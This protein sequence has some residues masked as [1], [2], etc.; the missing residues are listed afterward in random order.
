[1][2][3][4]GAVFTNDRYPRATT[5]DLSE[6]RT[7]E[8]DDTTRPTLVREGASIGAR[9]VVGDDL[10]I[11]RFALVGMGAVVTKSVRGLHAGRRHPGPGGRQ[12]LP[13]R[14]RDGAVRETAA[15]RKHRRSPALRAAAGTRSPAGS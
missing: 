8:P 11:G 12:R 13:V 5:P 10:T 1:M 14:G 15:G 4:A 9:A 7:S 3:G 6:L 2:V